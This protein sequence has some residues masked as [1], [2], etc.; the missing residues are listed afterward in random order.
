VA[1]AL[2][3]FL[4]WFF[5]VRDTGS[6][7]NGATTVHGPAGAPFTMTLPSGWRS[8]SPDD[9]SKL[10]G[11][12]LAVMQQT[13]GSGVVIVNTQPPTNADL[14]ALS[15]S[16]LD[17]LKKTIPDFNLIGSTTINLPAGQAAS[18]SYAR[19]KQK[20]ADTLVLVPVGG[21][22]YTLNAVVPGGQKKAAKQAADIIRSFNA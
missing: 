20:T 9:L 18:I 4:L 2:A 8:L 13:Q 14:N 15:K 17:K 6:N 12:P 1:T 16:V 11:S 5:V 21:R 19:P 7:A 22:I 10:P 3:A